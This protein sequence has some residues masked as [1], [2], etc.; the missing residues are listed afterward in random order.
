MGRPL[1]PHQRLAVDVLRTVNRV[2]QTSNGIFSAV[3]GGSGNDE[4]IG[5]SGN[6][7]IITYGGND[8]L[9]G[10]DGA[11]KLMSGLGNDYVDGGSGD[12]L[13]DENDGRV[14][15][16]IEIGETNTLIGGSGNDMIFGEAG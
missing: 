8:Q 10:G 13:L 5:G 1:M 4:I 3:R 14:N 11:D 6:D 9:Y 7:T 12:D 15:P 16:Q 2:Q